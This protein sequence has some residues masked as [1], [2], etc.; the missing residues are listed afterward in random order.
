M[1]AIGPLE[2]RRKKLRTYA[3]GS[4]ILGVFGIV[5]MTI[6]YFKYR[7]LFALTVERH[8]DTK[9]FIVAFKIAAFGICPL[10]CLFLIGLGWSV[11][12]YLKKEPE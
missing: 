5:N 9:W 1:N 4:I 11:I 8:P 7:Y 6:I 2:K 10:Y 3:F 12:N